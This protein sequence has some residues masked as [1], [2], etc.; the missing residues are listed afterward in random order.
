MT[1]SGPFGTTS[2]DIMSADEMPSD[3]AE[4]AGLFVRRE[5]NSI[6]VGTGDIR[7]YLNTNGEVGAGHDGPVAEVVVTHDTLVYCDETRY[8][9]EEAIDGDIQQVLE[10]GSLDEIGAHSII[11]AWG[12]ERGDRVLADV[13]IYQGIGQ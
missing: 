8:V 3:A 2:I 12:Q 6:F 11:S 10:P 7:A 4:A 13:L 9:P 1:T 5:D